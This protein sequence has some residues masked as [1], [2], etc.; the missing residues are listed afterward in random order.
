MLTDY[1][2]Q[3]SRIEKAFSYGGACCQVDCQACGRTYFVTS[4][5][6]GD[7][8]EGELEGLLENAKQSPDTFIEVPDYSYVSTMVHP[9]TNEEVVVGCLCDPTAGL[10]EMFESHA[11]EITKYLVLYWEAKKK[12]AERRLKKANESLNVLSE[13]TDNE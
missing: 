7:Y 9:M 10:S 11:E 5:G 6:H 3:Q 1:T 4:E 12:D 2:D 8:E 13:A